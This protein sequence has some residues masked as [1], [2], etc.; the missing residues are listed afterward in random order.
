VETLKSRALVVL[1]PLNLFAYRGA[2]AQMA[3]LGST[4]AM[5]IYLAVVVVASILVGGASRRESSR[6]GLRFERDREDGMAVLSLS[7][8]G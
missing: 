5:V 4:R 6:V 8:A 7:D 3:A 1:I 2:D